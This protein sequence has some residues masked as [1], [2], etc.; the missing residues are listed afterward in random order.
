MGLQCRLHWQ[1]KKKRK[2]KSWNNKKKTAHLLN[3]L[4]KQKF[5]CNNTNVLLCGEMH[6]KSGINSKQYKNTAS[7]KLKKRG[8]LKLIQKNEK[9]LL[10]QSSKNEKLTY[11][12]FLDIA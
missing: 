1:K 7:R 2:I 5:K 4:F 6:L 8:G 9:E 12:F 3:L 10:K 11:A